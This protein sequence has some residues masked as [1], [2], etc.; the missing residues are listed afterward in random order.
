MVKGRSELVKSPAFQRSFI[1][2]VV[3]DKLVWFSFNQKSVWHL[4]NILNIETG[5]VN[6]A[7]TAC[8]GFTVNEITAEFTKEAFIKKNLQLTELPSQ[9]VQ[10]FKH[11]KQHDRTKNLL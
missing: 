4:D 9:S 7:L 10:Q 11:T 6:W 3:K 5:P 2:T 8:K 1:F